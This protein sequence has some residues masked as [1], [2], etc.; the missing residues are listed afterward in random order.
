MTIVRKAAPGKGDGLEFVLSDDTIDR[1]GDVIEADGWDLSWFRKN[2][3]ALF[4]HNSSFPIGTWSN[5]RVEGGKLLG[6]LN[7]AARGTSQRIDELIALVEQGILRAVSVGFQPIESEP[8]EGSKMGGRRYLR[9]EL[10]ETSLV[11]VPAN[12]A[13][14]AVAKG[15]DI[16]ADTAALVFGEHAARDFGPMRRGTTGEHAATPPVRKTP[17]MEGITTSK[18]IEDAQNDLTRSRDELNALQSADVLDLER[19]EEISEHIEKQ[20]RLLATL[21]R[22]EAAMAGRRPSGGFVKAPETRDRAGQ[23]QT[24]PVRRALG[25]KDVDPFDL[26]VRRSVC[27]VQAIVTNKSI[28]EV[29]AK[30]YPNHQDTEVVVRAAVAGATTT[31]TGWAA[32]LVD[33]ATAA[34]LSALQPMS[35]FPSLAASGMAVNFG[36]NAGSIRI[37]ARAATPTISGSF[38]GEGGVIPVRKLGLSAKTLLPHKMAVISVFT[39]ELAKYSN[40]TIEDVVRQAILEDTAVTVD[41]LL[42]DATAGSA[43]R[44]AG[45]TNGVTALTAT[46]GGGYAAVLGDLKNLIGAFSSTNRSIGNLRLLMNPVDELG[47]ALMAGP[48]G[49][50]FGWSQQF[51]SRFNPIVSNTVP[52]GDVY[53]IDA[54]D[55]VTATGV[56]P[57][58][59][60]SEEAVLH[61][62]DTSPAQ[63]GTAGT[64]NAVA[65]PVQSMFQTGQIAIRMLWDITW[66]TRRNGSVAWIDDVTW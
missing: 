27:H 16:S 35:V 56:A 8:I 3:V 26:F 45:L 7:L 14:L 51:I 63:I 13:A 54:S 59:D 18:R 1:Y 31:T 23:M 43:V 37:P 2:P 39:R 64:P 53:L 10:L 11:S 25:Q 57:E 22:A 38:V 5:L 42:L 24:L 40:P 62:E 15:L 50:G 30:R 65:A 44:P 36:P 61:M 20:E 12:P 41:S 6:R 52:A 28:D 49:V 4:G 47:L 21:E 19:I 9:Q 55:F 29:L 17:V 60:L 32:E 46:A 58:F 48:D 66:N 34:F 33:T